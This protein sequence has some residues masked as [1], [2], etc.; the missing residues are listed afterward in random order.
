MAASNIAFEG[1][2]SNGSTGLSR[3][4][5]IDLAHLQNQTMGDKGLEAEL[6]TMFARVARQG[7]HELDGADAAATIAT[8]HRL[9]GAAAA[10]GGFRVAVAA[11]ELELRPEDPALFAALRSAVVEAEDFIS[12]LYR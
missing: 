1:P 10:V 7:L 11:G 5:P 9:K 3:A 4:R 2:E 8:A 12:T 6:L